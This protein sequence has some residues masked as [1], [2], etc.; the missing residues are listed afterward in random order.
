MGMSYDETAE[1]PARLH[2]VH[3]DG[4]EQQDSGPGEGRSLPSSNIIR[5]SRGG[6]AGEIIDSSAGD[7]PSRIP[8]RDREQTPDPMRRNGP[9]VNARR[10]AYAS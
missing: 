9:A 5:F 7:S 1:L 4:Q 10:R 6:I 3:R 8:I 2:D